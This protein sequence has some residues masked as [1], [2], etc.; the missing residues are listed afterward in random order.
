M[1]TLF[2]IVTDAKLSIHTSSPI[3]TLSAMLS[4]H[5]YLIRTRGFITTPSPTDAPNNLNDKTR[6]VE[7]ENR[8]ST[9]SA[10]ARYQSSLFKNEPG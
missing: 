7:H 9:N 3:Q 5:G 8:D 1:H 2:L 6:T 10:F 4:F